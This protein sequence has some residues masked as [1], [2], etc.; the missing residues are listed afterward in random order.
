MFGCPIAHF[1]V[2]HTI[3]SWRFPI[4]TSVH[5]QYTTYQP[6]AVN[7]TQ[8]TL[9]IL[10]YL[11]LLSISN[12][13]SHQELLEMLQMQ[14]TQQY[15]SNQVILGKCVAKLCRDNRSGS[16]YYSETIMKVVAM[17]IIVIV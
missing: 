6:V 17:P 3:V 14:L 13:I 8:L 16:D 4:Y 9:F 11:S 12:A 1:S 5:V 10:V 15:E 2:K 7:Y